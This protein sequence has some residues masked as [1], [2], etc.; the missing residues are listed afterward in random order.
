MM[1]LLLKIAPFVAVGEA[2]KVLIH[3]RVIEHFESMK[4]KCKNQ[5]E[6]G[7]I[8]L[9]MIRGPHLEITDFTIPGKQDIRKLYDFYRQDP[10]HQQKAADAWHSSGKTMAF[11]GDWHTHPYG[12][13]APSSTDKKSWRESVSG[14]RPQMV[15][16]IISPEE[17]GVY[18]T[19][20]SPLLSPIKRMNKTEDGVEGLVFE[21]S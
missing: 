8:L 4:A 6:A 16:V 11:L 13:P 10:I 14:Q 7:G 9:G 2:P 5:P 20:Y 21:W 15:F 12:E 18:M 3:Y 1:Y 17:W 19:S